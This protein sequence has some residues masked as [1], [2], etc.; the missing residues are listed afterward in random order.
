MVSIQEKRR[1]APVTTPRGW[2]SR[3]PFGDPQ[4][5][6]AFFR[7]CGVRFAKRGLDASTSGE[8]RLQER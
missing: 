4:A 6:A 1:E 2:G 5:E 8:L 3:G 7:L